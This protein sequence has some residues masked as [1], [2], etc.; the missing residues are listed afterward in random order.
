ML[1]TALPDSAPEAGPPAQRVEVAQEDEPPPGPGERH[2]HPVVAGQEAA[3]A[4]APHQGQQHHLP[5]LALEQVLLNLGWPKL[6][7]KHTLNNNLKKVPFENK[8]LSKKSYA[9]KGFNVK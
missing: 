9:E 4:A 5:L 1:L 7:K 2:R 3:G 6:L 8:C